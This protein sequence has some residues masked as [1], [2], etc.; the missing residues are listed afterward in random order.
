VAKKRESGVKRR[1]VIAVRWSNALSIAVAPAF[2]HTR[3]TRPKARIAIGA[4]GAINAADAAGAR[5]NGRTAVLCNARLS[6]PFA[7]VRRS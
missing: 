5:S 3:A 7:N 4:I 1:R 6:K 2:S